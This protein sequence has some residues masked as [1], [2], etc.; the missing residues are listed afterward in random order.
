MTEFILIYLARK[1][2]RAA[3]RGSGFQSVVNMDSDG[4]LSACPFSHEKPVR[5]S[6][7]SVLNITRNVHAFIK[8]N[9][10]FYF[11]LLHTV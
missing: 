2:E 6:I 7:V 10:V 3:N 9:L 4:D 1:S 11:I 5:K 8:F